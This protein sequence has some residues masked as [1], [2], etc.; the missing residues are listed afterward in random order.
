MAIRHNLNLQTRPLEIEKQAGLRV[1]RS[2]SNS[3][4]ILYRVGKSRVLFGDNLSNL[5][6]HELDWS[7]GLAARATGTTSSTCT[8]TTTLGMVS[9]RWTWII[10]HLNGWSARNSS[11]M[12]R[13][14]TGSFWIQLNLREK[15][16]VEVERELVRSGEVEV[17]VCASI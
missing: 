3:M 1:S 4:E 7:G 16:W 9:P 15:D 6:G 14:G 11:V 13:D 17:E 8:T 2:G 5:R 12:S 10:T